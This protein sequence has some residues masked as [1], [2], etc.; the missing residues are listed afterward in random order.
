MFNRNTVRKSDIELDPGLN[1][2]SNN[3]EKS[4]NISTSE[5]M[6]QFSKLLVTTTEEKQQINKEGHSFTTL[7]KDLYRIIYRDFLKNGFEI[8][9]IKNILELWSNPPFYI[10]EKLKL[11][12]SK[13]YH[14]NEIYYGAKDYLYKQLETLVG[15]TLIAETPRLEKDR[16]LENFI[17]ENK[18]KQRTFS[19][20]LNPNQMYQMIMGAFTSFKVKNNE[21]ELLELLNLVKIFLGNKNIDNNFKDKLIEELGKTGL[22]IYQNI[23]FPIQSEDQIIEISPPYENYSFQKDVMLRIYTTNETETNIQ[24][25]VIPNNNTEELLTYIEELNGKNQTETLSNGILSNLIF[26]RTDNLKNESLSN[27]SKILINNDLSML[28]KNDALLS[29]IKK[30]VEQ[31]L[32][33]F[34]N[35]FFSQLND[36]YKPENFETAVDNLNDFI[37]HLVSK[38]DS[39]LDIKD[40]VLEKQIRAG[41]H[42]KDFSN[43]IAKSVN[44]PS[45]GVSYS[46]GC[47]SLSSSN[48]APAKDISTGKSSIQTISGKNGE[49]LQF[50]TISKQDGSEEKFI[51][52][53]VCRQGY[54]DVC[55]LDAKCQFCN[56]KGT[57][58]YEHYESGT[59]DRLRSGYNSKSEI[60]NSARSQ[61]RSSIDQGPSIAGNFGVGVMNVLENFLSSIF[62]FN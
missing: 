31:V 58:V 29:P 35:K 25:Y 42:L 38:H 28:V 19:Y 22:D 30:D 39:R 16:D 34:V 59:L 40:K 49:S 27:I 17:V 18:F 1:P 52:C 46:G 43:P 13:N 24:Q 60:K 45:V 21:R 10:S 20:S 33:P 61:P 23:P 5:W 57:S 53:P 3:L 15:E 14:L 55:N 36:I 50:K 48:R 54:F 44:V 62:S 37:F 8:D 4:R 32:S 6:N 2:G 12:E 7:V 56:N 51:L 9:E 41:A 47:N 11:T 26:A